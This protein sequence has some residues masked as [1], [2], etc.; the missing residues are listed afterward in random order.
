M[1]LGDAIICSE[2][3]AAPR[4]KSVYVLEYHTRKS[5]VTVQRA[6]RTKYSSHYYHVTSLT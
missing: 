4:E 5:V 3:M 1:P 2:K 6:F